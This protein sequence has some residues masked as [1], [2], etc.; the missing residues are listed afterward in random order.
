MGKNNY[1]YLWLDNN[2]LDEQKNVAG[3][4]PYGDRINFLNNQK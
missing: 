1:D 4:H 2:G 3:P